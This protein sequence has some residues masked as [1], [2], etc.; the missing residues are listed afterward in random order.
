VSTVSRPASY[1]DLPRTDDV[2]SPARLLLHSPLRGV[3]GTIVRRRWHVEV[4]GAERFPMTGPVVVAAN[5]I[6]FLD[7]PLMAILGPRPVHALTKREMFVG[8]MGRLLRASG[9]IPIWRREPD[10]A[11][12]RTALRVLRDGGV[13][14]VF[15]EGSRGAGLMT[16][17]EGGAAYLAIATGA[18]VV[19]L[20]ML[21]TRAVGG[22]LN[23][24]PPPGTRMVMTYG[25]PLVLP[26]HGWP[27]R[28]D[29]VREATHQVRRAL[30]ATMREA[31]AATGLQLP[32]P[33]PPTTAKEQL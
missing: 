30:L 19:P 12:V 24:V 8:G 25:D 33:V 4:R 2:R 7:G 28:R 29:E 16:R 18:A 11:A 27:R 1:A 17:A 13:V 31:E 26:Q 3:T 20:S 22:S 23:S 15:P 10:P 9:Q 21:G 32:G 6:G 5:H 14:G